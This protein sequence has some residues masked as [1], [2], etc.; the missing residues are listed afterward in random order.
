MPPRRKS[1]R[2]LWL[3]G[4]LGVALLSWGIIKWRSP[5]TAGGDAGIPL[6]APVE[7]GL[8]LEEVVEPGEVESSRS[9]EI[10]CEVQSR[11]IG[12]TL[13]LELVLEG[14][15]VK[16]GD[17]LARL[18]DSVLQSDLLAQQIVVYNSKAYL[19][20]AQADVESAKMVLKEYEGNLYRQEEDGLESAEFVARENV[21]RAEEYLRYSERMVARGYVSDTQVE[22]DKFAVEKARKDLDSAQVRLQTLRNFTKQRTL[23]KLQVDVETAEARLRSRESTYKLDQLKQD[24]IEDQIKKCTIRAPATGQVVYAN[25]SRSRSMASDV[26]IGEGRTVRERQIMFRLPDPKRMRVV[27]KINESRINRVKPGMTAYIKIDALPNHDLTGKVVRVGEYPLPPA[28]TLTA[29]IKEYST[30]VDIVEPPLGLRSGMTAE[31]SIQVARYEN[32]IH[33]PL[34]AVFE[35]K[36]RLFCLVQ[37]LGEFLEARE[38]RVGAANDKSVIIRQGLQAQDQVV[39]NPQRFEN[40]V[41]F[42][43]AITPPPAPPPVKPVAPLP[44]KTTVPSPAKP[45]AAVASAT[46]KPVP[47]AVSRP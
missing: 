17:L 20:Q 21:R 45:K 10:R 7:K 35:R 41:V 47:A 4:L 31:V 13:I 37:V 5:A 11:A 3:A 40:E 1:R 6:L 8:F 42:P 26:L 43:A 34:P 18:D 38:V 30:E 12:G 25:D 9:I 44:A 22:A 15:Y 33:V 36:G 32:A 16:K 19:I 27:A 29:H 39:L 23:S 24:Q 14:S 2:R 46:E 28:S